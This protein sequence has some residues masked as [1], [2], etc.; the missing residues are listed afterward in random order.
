MIFSFI[1]VRASANKALDC[2]DFYE[3]NIPDD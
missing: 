3:E 1:Y 2:I